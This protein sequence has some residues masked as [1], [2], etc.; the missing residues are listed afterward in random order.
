MSKWI[1][2][3]ALPFGLGCASLGVFLLLLV[4]SLP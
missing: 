4:F 2:R 1:K 3:H